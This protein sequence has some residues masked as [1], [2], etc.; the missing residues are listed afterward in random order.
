MFYNEQKQNNNQN[1]LSIEEYEQIPKIKMRKVK[2]EKSCAICKEITQPAEMINRLPCKHI[3]HEN[4]A[5]EHLLTINK[6]CPVCKKP[7]LPTSSTNDTI[8]TMQYL[9]HEQ[10]Y[11][12]C[13][14]KKICLLLA[15]KNQT[16]TI[17]QYL[18][19]ISIIRTI[20]KC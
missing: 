15:I 11:K 17:V 20:I 12:V 13:T 18:I 16:Q 6:N 14:K 5:K 9:P 3:F 7:A 4:C 10:P 1:D 8:K 2:I 19:T